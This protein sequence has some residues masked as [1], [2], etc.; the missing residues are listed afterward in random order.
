MSRRLKTQREWCEEVEAELVQVKERNTQLDGT[1]TKLTSELKTQTSELE[2]LRQRTVVQDQEV[3][4]LHNQAE[5]YTANAE[6][7]AGQLAEAARAR[8]DALS[9]MSVMKLQLSEVSTARQRVAETAMHELT[10]VRWQA[11]KT[12]S[13]LLQRSRDLEEA[14]RSAQDDAAQEMRKLRG[15]MRRL[16]EEMRKADAATGGSCAIQ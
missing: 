10:E 14:L 4:L 15:E 6:T 8:D 16:R 2:E 12:E 7:L 1:C 11:M 13:A 5:A 9:E 3:A